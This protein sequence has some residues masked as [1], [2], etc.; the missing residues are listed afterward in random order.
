MENELP[1]VE[2]TVTKDDSISNTYMNEGSFESAQRMAKA[3]S[4]SNLVPAAYQNNIPNTMIALEMA[5]R[6]KVSPIMVMQ[7]LHIIQG[8]PSWSSPFIIAVINSNDKFRGGLKFEMSGTGKDRSCLAYTFDNA[9]QRIEGSTVSMAMAEAEGWIN[10]SGSKWK[11]MPEQMLRYRAAAFFGRLHCPE[12]LMGMQS[13]DE[14]ID[15]F[16]PSKTV[17]NEKQMD[18]MLASVKAGKIDEVTNVL[19]TV[20]IDDEQKKAIEQEITNQLTLTLDVT[21]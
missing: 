10:K 5:S 2:L 11:S 18:A 3:L 19:N 21:A 9:G 12:I 15:T 4:S 14:V 16:T 1:K 13:Q 8:K 20:N 7:N 17:L 6:I